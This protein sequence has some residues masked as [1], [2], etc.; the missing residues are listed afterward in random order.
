MSQNLT[1][2]FQQD[3]QGQGQQNNFQQAKA[4]TPV[5]KM[6][7]RSCGMSDEEI[8]KLDSGAAAQLPTEEKVEAAQ[9]C[10]SVAKLASAA[11]DSALENYKRNI[12]EV[13]ITGTIMKKDD[14][15]TEQKLEIADE[16]RTV[17]KAEPECNLVKSCIIPNLKMGMISD[18]ECGRITIEFPL[19]MLSGVGQDNFE[20]WFKLLKMRSYLHTFDIEI[21][22]IK[23][24]ASF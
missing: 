22:N 8:A 11:A 18:G 12:E 13:N 16:L 4:M 2:N 17:G 3:Q 9:W 6:A 23:R 5:E 24:H 14:E 20:I 19:N 7:L 1:N 10:D 15:I 21:K